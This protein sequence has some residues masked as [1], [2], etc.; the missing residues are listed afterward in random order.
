MKEVKLADLSEIPFLDLSKLEGRF[1]STLNFYAEDGWIM[2]VPTSKGLRKF[3]VE[4]VEG[5]YFAKN[6]ESKDDIYY[7]FLDFL[8]QRAS[9]PSIEKSLSGLQD[10]FLNLG[11]SLAKLDLFYRERESIGGG[12]SRMV[13]TE[14]E[15]IFLVCRSVFDLLQEIISRL[16]NTIDLVDEEVRKQPL[17]ETFS[18][19]IKLLG[20][21]GET[22]DLISKYGLPLS[23][24]GFYARN[25][26]FFIS[27]REFRDNIA[28]RGSS[29]DIIFSTDRGFAVRDTLMP[30][31]K[32]GVWTDEHKQNELCS[33]RPAIGY[34]I[35]ETFVACEDFSR[36]IAAIIKFPPP[37]A[38]GLRLYMRS[39]FNDYLV[40][41]VKAVSE[42]QW[43]D[44]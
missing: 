7:Y 12:I 24:A 15:Y 2:W 33:L 30:F 4:L 44:T 10:D 42:S 26:E 28:H 34:V 8:V 43:W 31:V 36:T 11:A 18:K 32:Y 14:V 40:K 3:R 1:V 37:I 5:L 19:V 13:S 17:P 39:Y 41:N 20:E 25:S 29:V 35:H 22:G 23:V 16:W 6:P 21:N 27:L 9:F 38:P